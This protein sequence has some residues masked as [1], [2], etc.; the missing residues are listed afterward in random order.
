M[1][2]GRRDKEGPT[3][4]P[5]IHTHKTRTVL[6][7][8]ICLRSLRLL[9]PQ[10][11]LWAQVHIDSSAWAGGRQKPGL[12]YERCP[13]ASRQCPMGLNSCQHVLMAQPSAGPR[14]LAP[15]SPGLMS[16]QLSQSDQ[17]GRKTSWKRAG[18]GQEGEVKWGAE[19]LCCL[20]GAGDMKGP[21]VREREGRGGLAA[22]QWGRPRG[23]FH[24]GGLWAGAVLPRQREEG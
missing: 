7:H 23:Y 22:T 13:D 21:V 9:G 5:L 6:Q 11:V 8:L 3:P 14:I 20:P 4:L 16:L 15:L 12:G 2:W 17:Q 1:L 18:R 10:M 19:G 24:Q